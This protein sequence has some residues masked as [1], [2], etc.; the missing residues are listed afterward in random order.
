MLSLKALS[1]LRMLIGASC[2][3]VPRQAGAI[4]GVPL[5]AGPES[6]LFGRMVGVRDFVLGAYL[7]KRVRDYEKNA[8]A[9]GGGGLGND[10]SSRPL[11]KTATGAAAP[12]SVETGV[13]SL[14]QQQEHAAATL[15]SA[16][17]LGLLCDLVDFAGV[18]VAWVAGDP[19]S[20]LGE[21]CIGGGAAIFAAVAGQYLW[22][23]RRV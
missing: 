4:W 17:W 19:I 16:V 6:V 3:L 13:L 8:S 11:L 23:S 18:G 7:W 2:V 9:L 21:V 5:A 20:P 12:G 14:S 22:M 10:S 15:K 1:S